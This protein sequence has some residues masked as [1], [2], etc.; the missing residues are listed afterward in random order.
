MGLHTFGEGLPTYKQ[1]KSCRSDV[2]TRFFS[3]YSI[4]RPPEREL[5]YL[6]ISTHISDDA[7]DF[8]LSLCYC[9]FIFSL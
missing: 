1:K 3:S 5:W 9:R 2:T 4:F 6:L 7:L 8:L